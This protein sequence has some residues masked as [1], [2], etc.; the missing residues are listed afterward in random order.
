MDCLKHFLS[1]DITQC[2][3][4]VMPLRIFLFARETIFP[5]PISFYLCYQICLFHLFDKTFCCSL[6]A[7]ALVLL[8]TSNL[9][10]ASSI[11]TFLDSIATFSEAIAN[12][13]KRFPIIQILE[14]YR[15]LGRVR[16]ELWL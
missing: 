5:F 8:F 2:L 12:F 6:S 13:F 9:L 10:I 15:E 7:L 4:Y 11:V 3:F 14:N 1:I 16:E